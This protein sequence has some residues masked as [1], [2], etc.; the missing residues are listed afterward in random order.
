[1][2]KRKLGR[3][4]YEI[5]P[6]SYGAMELKWLHEK[7]AVATL[8]RVLDLGINYI[9]TSP[10]YGMSEYYIGNAIPFSITQGYM[11]TGTAKC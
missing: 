6:L 11:N 5:T 1:M 10:E 4:G 2:E 7:E 8:N 9:D 3:T